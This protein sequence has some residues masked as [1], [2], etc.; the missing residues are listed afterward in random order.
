MKIDL[1]TTLTL[2]ISALTLTACDDPNVHNAVQTALYS[3]L[4][5]GSDPAAQDRASSILTHGIVESEL[6]CHGRRVRRARQ[7]R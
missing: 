2:A 3:Y 7:V 4:P 1:R 5:D 6:E